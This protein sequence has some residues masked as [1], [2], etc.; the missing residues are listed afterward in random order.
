MIM[1]FNTQP[2]ERLEIMEKLRKGQMLAHPGVAFHVNKAL[3]TGDCSGL[4]QFLRD[5][6]I[7]MLIAER[8]ITIAEAQRAENPFR[9]YPD[10][11]DVREFLS[12]PLKLGYVNEFND[13]FGIDFDVL[14][15]PVIILGRVGSGKS[16]LNKYILCQM[17]R[18]PREF[19]IIIPDI[20]GGEYRHL[21]P[22]APQLKVLIKEKIKINPLQKPK[23]MT[24]L[25]YI[26]F[27]SK[28][29]VSE[30]WL[31]GTSENI[32]ISALEYLYK[33]R[34]IFDDGENYPTLKDLYNVISAFLES[35]NS[36]KYRDILLVL[37]N[38]LYPYTIDDSFNCRIGIPHDVWRTENVVLEVDNFTDNMYCFIA[39][40]IAGLRYNYNKKNGLTGSKLR[41]LLSVDEARILF[42]AHR[43]LSTF[44]ETYIN[45]IITKTREFGIGFIISSPETASFN[46]T[47]RSI[48]YL[49]IAFPLND[50]AD[51]NFIR[52]S[53]GLDD[54]Q[55]AHIF[56]LPRYGQ[57]IVRYG[58]YEKPFLLAVPLFKIK[59]QLSDDEVKG[60][61]SGF[62]AKLD[63]EIKTVETPW[64]VE[65]KTD[66]P[67]KNLTLLYFLSNEPFTK[68]NEMKKAPG[69]KSAEEVSNALNWL[70][71]N[72][73]IQKESFRI[74]K[75]GRK[76]TFAILTEKTHKYFG[77]KGPKG[78]GGF[79]HSLYQYLIM[80][81]L[82]VKGIEA[83]V[84]GRIKGTKACDVLAFTKDGEV[85]YEVT[86]HF[87]NL[88]TNVR[89]DL[90]SGVSEVV[91]VTRDDKDLEVAKQAVN[92]DKE[93]EQYREKISFR[94]ID[95]FFG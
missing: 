55:A 85:A 20:K 77:T 73:F 32:L 82:A 46:Q 67:P 37:Q 54:D 4:N 12:S 30:N 51:L 90:F 91:I 7:I 58:G 75:R 19:N 93:M 39:S 2:Q 14:S 47:V 28:L 81:K 78:K 17:L 11:D 62:Y 50:A 92:N 86:L 68:V 66:I 61:M 49:K 34:G 83:K 70:E 48:S 64:P 52:E 69:F 18:R 65:V 63:K 53:F 5:N 87:E 59:K 35:K 88:L 56:K 89:Q 60:R 3:S 40:Y 76:S 26:I 29:F 74:S 72:G 71:K 42:K 38:R 6:P 25:E 80:K 84:E 79:E 9:P 95:H 31:G 23:W 22:I 33:K 36:Y 10:P 13:M 44:G 21:L 16:Q 41:T 57:A 8:N 43:D 94:T 45:E 24:P 1:M 15:M 27:F